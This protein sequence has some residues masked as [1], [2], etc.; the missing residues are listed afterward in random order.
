MME[1][2]GTILAA[3]Q[4]YIPAKIGREEFT[5]WVNALDADAKSMYQGDISHAR[6]YPLDTFLLR[7]TLVYCDLFHDGGLEGARDLGRFNAEH[8]L[9]GMYKLFARMGSV[10][11]IINRGTKILPTY[12]RPCSLEIGTYDDNFCEVTVTEFPDM[13]EALEMRIMGW[14]EKA[15]EIHGCSG[16]TIDMAASLAR[17][18]DVS[19]F[20]IRWK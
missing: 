20:S 12:Y 17:G 9:A 6:W 11:F 14:M 18:D 13:H 4:S 5:R 1:V 8:S 10:E 2:K 16:V 19:T 3:M 7:P 15:L